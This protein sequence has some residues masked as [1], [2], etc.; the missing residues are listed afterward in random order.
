MFCHTAGSDKPVLET[1]LSWYLG[2]LYWEILCEGNIS[3]FVRG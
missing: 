1:V 2:R 3:G